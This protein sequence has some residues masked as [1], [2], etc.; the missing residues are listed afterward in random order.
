MRSLLCL[1]L[2]AAACSENVPSVESEGSAGSVALAQEALS[3]Q[4]YTVVNS[5]SGQ[6]FNMASQS[7]KTVTVG[8][9]HVM[10]FGGGCTWQCNPVGSDQVFCKASTSNCRSLFTNPHPGMPNLWSVYSTLGADLAHSSVG[11]AFLGNTV[12]NQSGSGHTFHHAYDVMAGGCS[13][14]AYA[15]GD[16]LNPNALPNNNIW[17]ITCTL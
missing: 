17:T 8:R 1:C 11:Q 16:V 10:G 3:H 5:N 7:G 13:P 12:F 14:S 6:A 15:D 4:T 9:L 2:L